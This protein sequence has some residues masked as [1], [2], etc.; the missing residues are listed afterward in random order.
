[1]VEG[2]VTE[3]TFS[4]L[5]ILAMMIA[6][7]S[8]LFISMPIHE[9]AHAHAAYKEGDKTAKILGRYTIAP[10]AHIDI[11][12]LIF[13]LLFGI[14]FAKP[15]PIDKRNFKRGKKSELRVA[16]AGVIANFCLAILSCFLF[17]FLFNVWPALFNDYGFLSELYYD[18]FSYMISLNF[19][20]FFFN[21]LP[22]Y[23]LDGFR[24]VEA[25][26]KNKNNGY[27]TFMRRSSFWIMLVL[28]FTGL[29]SL[30]IGFFNSL[31]GDLFLGWFD[32]LFKLVM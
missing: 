32:K 28:L 5:P 10:F 17:A 15:V 21:L 3:Q 13:L 1:M 22:I 31:L 9:F 6:F 20:F 11:S 18:F 27:L 19:M 14:G 30:Y 16:F 29:L 24:V 26:S 8:A 12:G 25:L 2:I 23:P 7:L 4:M